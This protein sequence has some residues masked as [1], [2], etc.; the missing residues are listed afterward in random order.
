VRIVIADLVKVLKDDGWRQGRDGVWRKG[1]ACLKLDGPT[2]ALI[3]QF[4]AAGHRAGWERGAYEEQ[5]QEDVEPEP[6]LTHEELMKLHNLDPDG[7]DLPDV[8]D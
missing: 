6:K 5:Q 2:T 4:Y 3:D 1:K 7:P 8:S